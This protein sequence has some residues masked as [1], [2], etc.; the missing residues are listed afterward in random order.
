[1]SETIKVITGKSAKKRIDETLILEA[2]SLLRQTHMSIKE[3]TYWLGFEDDS[4]FVKF[5][6]HSEGM[7]PNA[8][9]SN[10]P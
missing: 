6:K 2:K 4:Y 8:Y 1:V 10:N 9:R 5:F 3:I 7:T